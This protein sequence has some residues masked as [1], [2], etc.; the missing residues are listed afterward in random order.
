MKLICALSSL[1]I[2]LFVGGAAAATTR[3]LPEGMTAVPLAVVTN[4]RDSSVSELAL[5]L[6]DQAF[7]HGIYMETTS[8]RD[9]ER[10]KA[11]GQ[12]Y[13]LDGIESR[14]GVVLGQGQGVKAIFLRGMIEPQGDH[15]T[16]V[17]KYLSNGIFRN[18]DECA[19]KLERVA[20]Y[21]WQLV[22]AYDDRPITLIQVRTWALGISTLGNV[23]PGSGHA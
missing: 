23:C 19:V 16:L 18:Y 2:A 17:I 7:V 13:W 15:G 11:S 12:V 9:G 14:D 6:D 4:D 1:A 21:D 20:P 22:N 3:T 5:M 8:G 10:S